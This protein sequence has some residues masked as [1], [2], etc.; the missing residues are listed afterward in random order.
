MMFVTRNNTNDG[1]ERRRHHAL[2]N[3]V[4]NKTGIAIVFVSNPGYQVGAILA[5]V[6]GYKHGWFEDY[7]WVIR[8]NPDVLIRNDTFILASMAVDSVHGIFVDCHDKLCP[9]GRGCS[10][11]HVHTEIFA[12]RPRAISL[13]ALLHVSETNAEDMAIYSLF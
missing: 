12:I 3:S 1:E 2:I 13:D 4:F 9:T 8:V 11:R 7:D 10:S 6:E 5:L